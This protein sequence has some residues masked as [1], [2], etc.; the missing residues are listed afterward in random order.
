MQFRIFNCHVCPI[1][2]WYS[3]STL[4]DFK[5]INT[6]TQIIAIMFV[7]GLAEDLASLSTVLQY[8]VKPTPRTSIFFL[9]TVPCYIALTYLFRFEIFSFFE[10]YSKSGGLVIFVIGLSEVVLY[11][12]MLIIYVPYSTGHYKPIQGAR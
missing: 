10:T 2:V 1:V 8:L 12:L 6:K 7:V 4:A 9:I 11:L 5:N 3:R